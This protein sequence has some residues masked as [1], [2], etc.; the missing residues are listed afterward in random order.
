M[1]NG[2]I[3]VN[4]ERGM[5]SHDVVFKLRKIL[6]TKK[7]G[8]TGTLDPE[9]NGVLPICIG[10]ATRISDYVMNSGKE[11][12]AEITIGVQTTTEDQ[13][14]EVVEACSITKD[15]FTEQA[16]DDALESLTGWI[17]QTPPM[18]SAVKVNGRKLYEYA[19]QG[20]TIDRP[21][22]KVHIKFIERT[23]PLLY[24][25][26]TMKFN[27]KVQCGKG[28][29]IR[30]LA[31]QIAEALQSIGH[32]SL[33]T[34]TR[35][36][37]FSLEE[38]YTLQELA[39]MTDDEIKSRLRPIEEGLKHLPSIEVDEQV[40]DKIMHGQKL[41]QFNPPVTE[42]TVMLYDDEALAIYMPHPEKEGVLKAKKVF[43]Q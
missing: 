10:R 13:T 21:S 29:Y 9:V 22:R 40:K 31:T 2:I 38:S 18:F 25:D 16:V 27:I 33:L 3:A 11:Y 42:E 6:R 20:Q 14:G 35:S 5:T 8:H 1:F 17:D 15:Q 26:D 30:T 28:T 24:A 39:A 41:K 36:G 43:I 19:R 32:M 7:V 23:S 4:K 37:G 34:R 12:V